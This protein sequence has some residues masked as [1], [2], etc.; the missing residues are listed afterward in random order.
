M[1]KELR[2]LSDQLF[3][4]EGKWEIDD[5]PFT[6]FAFEKEG[7]V[8]TRVDR[9]ADGVRVENPNDAPCGF[10]DVPGIDEYELDNKTPYGD[11]GYEPMY[12]NDE[13]YD[14]VA[15]SFDATSGVY[16]SASRY[17]QGIE[18]DRLCWDDDGDP[19]YVFVTT[20]S[21]SDIQILKYNRGGSYQGESADVSHY[22]AGSMQ[23]CKTK[24]G[25]LCSLGLSEGYFEKLESFRALP[26]LPFVIEEDWLSEQ[27]LNSRI[28][29]RGKGITAPLLKNTMDFTQSQQQKLSLYSTGLSDEE[30][31]ELSTD[32]SLKELIIKSNRSSEK[33]RQETLA[34][35]KRIHPNC[36]IKYEK[37]GLPFG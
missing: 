28:M 36:F 4:W 32:L 26:W 31:I 14:G 25:L 34:E 17:E 8:I 16:R 20:K 15:F 35:L 18:M 2:V 21:G 7:S 19:E 30:I 10:P 3:E 5:E 29:L 9:Y 33:E 24:E 37:D 12:Y 1:K 22:N 27:S 6:G 11:T 13:R 23:F